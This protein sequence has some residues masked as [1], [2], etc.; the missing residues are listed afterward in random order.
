MTGGPYTS[1]ADVSTEA[2]ARYAKQLASHLGRRAEVREEGDGAVRLL[3]GNGG[4][5]LLTSGDGVLTLA[6]DAA[7]TTALGEVEE[8]VGRHLERFGQRAGLTVT[9]HRAPGSQDPPP[10]LTNRVRAAAT[11]RLRQLRQAR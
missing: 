3:F 10:T 5:C 8:V 7:T 1:R 11:A 6:A 9:W 2:P 4:S